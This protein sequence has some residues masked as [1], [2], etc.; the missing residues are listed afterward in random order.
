MKISKRVR[1]EAIEPLLCAADLT[2]SGVPAARGFAADHLDAETRA[3]CLAD[4]AV[5]RVRTV[6]GY[7][8]SYA[9]ELLE[10]AHLLREGWTP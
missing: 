3:I 9:E 8:D 7:L 5:D 10:A 4:D 1:E 2:F 6:H